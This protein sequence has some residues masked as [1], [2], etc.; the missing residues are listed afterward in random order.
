MKKYDSYKDS[1]IEWIGKIPSHWES[2]KIS[3]AFDRIGSGTTPESGNP[4][5]H[6]NGTVN[7]LNTGD[8]NDG[9]L[10]E[11]NKK[12]TEKAL[13]DYSSLKLFPSGS[14]VIA[15]YGATIGKTALLEFETTTNQACCVFC[16]SDIIKLRFLQYWFVGNKEH[17]I[18]LAIGGGQPNIS[19]NILKDV[20][21]PCPKFEEQTAIA[22]FLDHKTA[23]IDDLIAKK[24]RLIALLEE[25]RTATINQAV[26]K[27]LDPT[28]PMKDSGIEWLGEI[29]KHWEV[30]RMKYLCEITTG[31][32]DT[33]NR[34]DDGLYPF[35][36][37]SQTIERISSYSFDGEA[38]LTAGDGVGVC[39]VWHYVN[40][41]FDF[42]QRV[43]M[44]CNFQHVLGKYLFY[45]LKENFGKE[46]MKLSAKSTVDSLRRP[47]FQNFMVCFG[48]IEEQNQIVLKIEKEEKRISSILTKTL[49]EI[50]LLKEYK[51]A[52]ISEVVTGK[53]DVRNE[54][55]N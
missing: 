26:T 17:I 1:G 48:S 12:I 45:Y 39:K 8:L 16:E 10:F 34:E 41:K 13:E 28:V 29:P 54:K 9:I 42:H 49:Q 52:L 33:E 40:E 50:E 30:K 51:T 19:Q 44:L 31:S 23:Q 36:V 32:K 15:M 25:E 3:H 18:N 21:V 53:V 2:W 43:Y 35:F 6:E 4:E 24:E 55:L 47:M 46:V 20:R 27:G 14:L 38:I 11:C 5:Y 7:W 22:N 37:R